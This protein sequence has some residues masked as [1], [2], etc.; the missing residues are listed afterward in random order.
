MEVRIGERNLPLKVRPAFGFWARLKGW[1]FAT[2]PGEEEGLLL[3]PCRR[4]HTWGMRF[5]IDAVYLDR[6]GRV[7]AVEDNLPPGRV[8][9]TYE[10][11]SQVLELKAGSARACGIVAGDTLTFSGVTCRGYQN[12][13]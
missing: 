12:P 4:I 9:G 10:G 2:P 6:S 7:L 5:S 8:G 11:C 3:S 1:M 13:P